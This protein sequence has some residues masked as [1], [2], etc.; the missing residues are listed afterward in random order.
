MNQNKILS[1]KLPTSEE[2]IY[3]HQQKSA[4]MTLTVRSGLRAGCNY[5]DGNTGSADYGSS[6]LSRIIYF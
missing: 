3:L 5:S 1:E 6:G 4:H 2:A